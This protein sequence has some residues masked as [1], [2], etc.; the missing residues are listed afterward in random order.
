MPQLDVSTWFSQVFWL[1]VVFAAL[2]WLVVKRALPAI[3]ATIEQRRDRIAD[4]LDEAERLRTKAEAVLKAAQMELA[5]ARADAHKMVQ[6]ARE[7]LAKELDAERRK[8]EE[9]L[10]RRIAAAKQEVQAAKQKA[11]AEMDSAIGELATQIVQRVGGVK[12]PAAALKKAVARVM[13]RED[14]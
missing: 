9:A 14:G 6:E 11:M 5:E 12:V 13:E 3:G 10:T 8:V 4:D 7:T 2:Y 1:V